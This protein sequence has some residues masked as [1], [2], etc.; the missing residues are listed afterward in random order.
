[1]NTKTTIVI[2]SFITICLFSFETKAE[3]YK[4]DIGG[5]ITFKD[6][7]CAED[8]KTLEFDSSSVLTKAPIGSFDGMS[9]A[10]TTERLKSA[11][12]VRLRK[13]EEIYIFCG[14]PAGVTKEKFLEL[15]PDGKV[16]EDSPAH[17]MQFIQGF[18]EYGYKYRVE[19]GIK[20]DL[21][22][23]ATLFLPSSHGSSHASAQEG[24]EEFIE[25]IKKNCGTKWSSNYRQQEYCIKEETKSMRELGQ[26]AG[27]YMND[28][29]KN[30][31]LTRCMDKWTINEHETY[32]YR[33]TVYC[34]KKEIAAFERLQ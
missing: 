20:E 27:K 19:W 32:D 6:S 11:L 4:C 25:G 17:G 10:C 1:M 2:V 8:N 15:L 34:S 29:E 18:T 23:N 26:L 13:G 7:P 33:Q 24:N 31:I 16:L 22:R 5:V 9:L 12:T 14:R 3:I 21:I 28:N 30:S